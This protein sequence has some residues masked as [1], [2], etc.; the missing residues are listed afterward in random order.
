MIWLIFVKILK[1]KVQI[2]ELNDYMIADMLNNK[3]PYPIV[4]G[5]FIKGRKLNIFLVFVTQFYFAVSK[6]VRLNFTHYLL[7][8]FQT[9][10]KFDKVNLIVH[11]ILT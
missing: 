7:R 6:N 9:N 1:N 10:E 11:L 3:K 2:K 5:L 4:T 8:K